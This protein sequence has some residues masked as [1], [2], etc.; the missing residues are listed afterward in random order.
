MQEYLDIAAKLRPELDALG[1]CLFLDRYKSLIREGT[2]L[3]FQIWR[4]EAALTAWRVNTS[5]HKAQTLGRTRVF[6][7]YR[8]RI[9][10]VIRE[11]E[12]GKPSWQPERLTSY[13]DAA[14]TPPRYMMMVETQSAALEAPNASARETFAS[15]YREGQFAHVLDVPSVAVALELSDAACSVAS[16]QRCRVCEIERDYGM[17]DRAQ[18]PQYYPPL[19]RR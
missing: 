11:L 4:D 6:A 13:N 1:G 16:T 18:A 17:Y 14:H 10:Q 15:I 8:L 19:D 3:S 9:A 7:D 5:H 12:P 2:I